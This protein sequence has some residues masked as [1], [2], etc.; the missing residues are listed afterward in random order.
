VPLTGDHEPG[1]D[2]Q[3]PQAVDQPLRRAPPRLT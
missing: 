1:P 3:G 2:R